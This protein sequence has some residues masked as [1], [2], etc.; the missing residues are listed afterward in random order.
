MNVPPT[1]Y[2]L[3]SAPGRAALAV[4]RV[5]GTRALRVLNRLTRTTKPPTPRVATRRRLYAPTISSRGARAEI[6]D[7]ALAL[8]FP[9]PHSYTGEDVVELHVHGGRAVVAAVLGAVAAYARESGDDVRQREREEGSI[10]AYARYAEAG[11]FTRR[12]FENMRVDLTEAEGIAEMIDAETEA[13]R[14]AAVAAAGGYMRRTYNEWQAR[15]LD[16]A[17]TTAAIIDFSEEG[18]YDGDEAESE[19]ALLRNAAR[20]TAE[21]LADVRAQLDQIARSEIALRGIRLALLGPPNA[22]KSSLLN[23]LARRDA[24]IVSSAPGTTRDVVEVALDVAGHK[25]VLADTAG[26]RGTTSVHEVERIGIARAVERARE[27]DVVLV[28][29][30]VADGSGGDEAEWRAELARTVRENCTG[31]RVLLAVN[32]IDTL[33]AGTDV[34]AVTAAAAAEVADAAEVHAISCAT[35]AGVDALTRRLAAVFGELTAAGVM[36]GEAPVGAS[37]RVRA[38]LAEALEPALERFLVHATAGEV[39]LASEEVRAA[40]DALGRITGSTLGVEDVLGVVF[41][42][43]CVGK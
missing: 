32:K 34:A 33:P 31:K 14:V 23:V 8:Y 40:A 17:A 13:E 30:P 24:A 29:L 39:V 4:V 21:L 15:L 7:D 38:L 25:A 11:E 2:A 16:V 37:E 26:V 5:S 36:T 27:A 20:I 6:L 18:Y 41:A 42:R 3:S 22:G 9:A 35:G 19:E 12:A 10:E 43:F 28:V 1:I